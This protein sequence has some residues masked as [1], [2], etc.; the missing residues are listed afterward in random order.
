MAP[1]EW[2]ERSF[3]LLSSLPSWWLAS[4]VIEPSF[5]VRVS[6]LEECSQASKRPCASQ[7]SPFVCWHGLRKVVTPPF[8]LHLRRWSPGMSLKSR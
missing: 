1:L 2:T 8:S 5:S 3:G 7:A 4:T 6:R